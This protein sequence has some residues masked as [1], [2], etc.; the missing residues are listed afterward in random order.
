MSDSDDAFYDRVD[1]LIEYANNQVTKN[2]D[3]GDVSAS[4]MYALSRYNAYVSSASFK[5]KLD[6]KNNKED[7]MK[8]FVD[9]YK[10]VL[11]ENIDDY[12]ANFNEYLNIKA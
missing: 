5:N 11:E 2:A 12:I 10:Q 1:S 7:I 9:E 3:H 4:F 6:M 8:Y